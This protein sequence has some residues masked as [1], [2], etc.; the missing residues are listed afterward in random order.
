M[1]PTNVNR[2]SKAL[3]GRKIAEQ[4]VIKNILIWEKESVWQLVF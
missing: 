4:I 1:Y 3:I 2:A